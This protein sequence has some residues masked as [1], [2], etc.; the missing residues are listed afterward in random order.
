MIPSGEEMIFSGTCPL[1][2]EPDEFI[3]LA[4]GGGG[5]L[6]QQLI[7]RV[8]LPAF[9]NST[10]NNR[11]DGA[12]V[13][14][15]SERLALTTDG[16]VVKPLFFPGGDIGSLS[17][18]G[19][20]NDLA[21]CGAEP[22]FMGA[23]FILEEGFSRNELARI[24]ASMQSAAMAA[25][26]DIVTGDTKVVDKGKGDGIFIS[27]FGVGRISHTLSIQP[28]SVRHGD[29][30]LLSGD[31]GR[32]GM[33]VM[34]VRENLG[35]ES[36]LCS[37]CAPL[38]QPAL[39][40]IRSGLS[41]HCMRDLTRGGLATALNEI[42]QTAGLEMEIDQNSVPVCDAVRGACEILG[43]DPLYVANEG[44]FILI[45]P[46]AQSDLALKILTSHTV[47]AG[48]VK[49]G[50]VQ[51]GRAGQVVMKTSAGARRILDLLSGE[52]LPRIC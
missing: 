52:Q 3:R 32:H 16:F 48:A 46:Q 39:A 38:H 14:I 26:I 44:R 28:A 9:N 15:G 22:L 21:M 36:D 4:H 37:D 23:S 1:S 19:T 33:A 49:I 25:Q 12:E 6:T 31:V 47:A 41:V 7:E 29:A 35:F 34:S 30:I 2:K 5:R 17:V 42:A 43:L 10:L 24:V 13:K 8:F 40:L 18:F 27:A 45:L 50:H 51:Q 20:V 11:H